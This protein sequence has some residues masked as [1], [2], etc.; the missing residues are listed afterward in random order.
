[1]EIGRNGGR[2]E[3]GPDTFF[4]DKLPEPGLIR[5]GVSQTGR[6]KGNTLDV[7]PD[8][9][10]LNIAGSRLVDSE[11]G[12]MVSRQ[13]CVLLA[14]RLPQLSSSSQK[15]HSLAYLLGGLM[16][17]GHVH[18]TRTHGEVTFIQKP[19]VLKRDFI[20][21]MNE[22]LQENYGKAFKESAKKLSSGFIRGQLVVGSA[23]A[24]RC[25][26]KSIATAVRA[27]QETIVTT[28]LKATPRSPAISSPE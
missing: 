1:V 19:D 16:T 21:R 9:K 14:E 2:G 27:E 25:Y 8:H 7:T 11:I 23:N 6:M 10:M 4:V 20:A 22:A 15:E 5:V 3:A 17:D 26:S 24:Y 13:D 12:D 18:L 28:L